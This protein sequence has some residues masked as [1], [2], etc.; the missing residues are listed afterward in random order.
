MGVLLNHRACKLDFKTVGSTDELFLL[1]GKKK[2]KFQ[3]EFFWFHFPASRSC[4][5]CSALRNLFCGH[6]F[7]G[8]DWHFNFSLIAWILSVSHCKAGFLDITWSYRCSLNP[9]QFFNISSSRSVDTR[10][11]P[12]I[13]VLV[14]LMLYADIVLSF[15]IQGSLLTCIHCLLDQNWIQLVLYSVSSD[16]QNLM[17]QRNLQCE[18]YFHIAV[19]RFPPFMSNN[20]FWERESRDSWSTCSRCWLFYVHFSCPPLLASLQFFLWR[21]ALLILLC[22]SEPSSVLQYI[23]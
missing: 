18:Q 8:G 15:Y 7:A 11:G 23:F 12:S 10:T 16:S 2:I 6:Q 9:F 5:E 19:L 17:V 21:N 3:F 13:P 14:L 1:R 22:F 4:S 20:S